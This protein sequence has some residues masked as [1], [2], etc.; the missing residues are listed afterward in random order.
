VRIILPLITV[1]FFFLHFSASVSDLYLRSELLVIGVADNLADPD[2][3]ILKMQSVIRA[4][5]GRKP[6][7]AVNLLT[8]CSELGEE[9]FPLLAASFRDCLSVGFYN[10]EI[11][12][13]NPN[14]SLKIAQLL[15]DLLWGDVKHITVE[16]VFLLLSYVENVVLSHVI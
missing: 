6:V 4:G 13:I 11:L 3:L 10:L 16:L 9:V 7:L 12:T 14:P 2:V 1:L 5:I 8:P 15:V